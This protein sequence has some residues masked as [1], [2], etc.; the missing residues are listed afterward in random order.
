MLE[1]NTALEYEIYPK[2]KALFS[3]FSI[4]TTHELKCL[5]KLDQACPK[6]LFYLSKPDLF[7]SVMLLVLTVAVT[8]K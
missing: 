7:P 1:R 5:G 4:F 6:Q 3:L 2:G 8:T